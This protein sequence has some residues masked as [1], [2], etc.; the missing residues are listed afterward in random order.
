MKKLLLLI[1]PIIFFSN[2]ISAKAYDVKLYLFYGD[3]CPHCAAEEEYLDELQD[4]YDYLKVVKYEV[5]YNEK[6]ATLMQNV[7]DTFESSARGVPYTIIGDLDLSGYSEA[8]NK[9]IE[10]QIELVHE[11]GSE[12]VVA[13]VKKAGKFLVLSDILENPTKE[14]SKVTIPLIGEVDAKSFSL[15]LIA[16]TI[17]LVDGFNPCAMWILIFLISFLITTKDRK[18]M[19][20]LGSVFLFTSAF[21]YMLFMMSWLTVSIQITKVIWIRTAIALIAL[22]AGFINLRSYYRSTKL[23]VGCEVVDNKKRKSIINSIKKFVLEKNLGLAI[24]GIMALAVSVNFIE[25]ACSAGLPLLFTSVLSM[26][27]LPNLEYFMYILIYILFFLIDDL[28]IFIISMFTFK[29][30]GLSN[31]YSKYSHL[32][33]GVV[34]FLIGLLLIIKPEWVMFNF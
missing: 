3:G 4:K 29:V 24:I 13:A 10:S 19:W 11:N 25:L 16:A 32:I 28:I 1:I 34:M 12:D 27:D 31:K 22:V 33:G 15:P 26:N 6:N 20:I 17:G 7:K 30:T 21:I 9:K 14:D 2:V 5:W 18:K 8:F 23:E